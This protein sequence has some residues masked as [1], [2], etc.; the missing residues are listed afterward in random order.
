MLGYLA[1]SPTARVSRDQLA[2][3]LW[4]VPRTQGRHSLRQEMRHVRRAFGPEAECLVADRRQVELLR[5]RVSVDTDRFTDLVAQ[6]TPSSVREACALYRGDLLEGLT[7][8]EP[9]FNAWLD[10]R[11]AEFRRLAV[12]AHER[13]LEDLAESGQ[14]GETLAVARRLLTIDPTRESAYRRLM[15]IYADH[16]AYV[17]VFTQFRACEQALWTARQQRPSVE[18]Q[19]LLQTLSKRA[20]AESSTVE[21]SAVPEF[22]TVGMAARPRG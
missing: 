4:S 17:D 19:N 8:R 12:T 3:V 10:E 9:Q 13:R 15:S 11:R 5:E 20:T 7:T 18:T 2:A 6:L 14:S 16:G 21:P 1:L 22:A